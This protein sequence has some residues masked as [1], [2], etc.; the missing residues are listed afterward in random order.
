MPR[1]T[2]FTALSKPESIRS[3]RF[4]SIDSSELP[5]WFRGLSGLLGF[6]GLDGE[7]G[8]SPVRG[9]DGD[10]GF[11]G[12]DGEKGLSPARGLDADVGVADGAV[13]GALEAEAVDD[14]RSKWIMSSPT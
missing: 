3:I 13:E 9:L 5:R 8:M 14:A 10:A 1:M 2:S 7:K 6:N 11:S 12:L 4:P